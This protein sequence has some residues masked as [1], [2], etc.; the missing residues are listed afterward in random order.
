M[1]P[2]AKEK[3]EKFL[4]VDSPFLWRIAREKEKEPECMLAGC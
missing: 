2:C 3:K 4:Q 1:S